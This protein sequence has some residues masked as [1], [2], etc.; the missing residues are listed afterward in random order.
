MTKRI[1]VGLL[2]MMGMIS[3]PAAGQTIPE[4]GIIDTGFAMIVANRFSVKNN[5][6]QNISCAEGK[7]DRLLGAAQIHWRGRFEIPPGQDFSAAAVQERLYFFCDR[8]VEPNVYAL[9]PGK[10]YSL[11][12]SGGTVKLRLVRP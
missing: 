5:T 7:P 8:P 12:P 9:K 6:A 11:L 2:F 1:K 3:Q 10:R 4:N